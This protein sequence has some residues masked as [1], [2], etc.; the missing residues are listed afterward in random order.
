MADIQLTTLSTKKLADLYAQ[1]EERVVPVMTSAMS[2]TAIA[3]IADLKT[4]MR[5]GNDTNHVRSGRLRNSMG[6]ETKAEGSLIKTLL[7]SMGVVYARIQEFGGLI[8]PKRGKYLA[9][10]LSA[11]KTKAGVAR[12]ASPRDIPGLVFLKS[13]TGNPI[14]AQRVAKGK[15]SKLVPMFVLVKSVTLKPTLGLRDT[16]KKFFGGAGSQFEG[17]IMKGVE[18]VMRG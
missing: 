11:A 10:P 17:E 3:T 4:R 7:G 14:L 18:K 1:R 12:Y 15:K 2:R 16:I 6:Q 9:I 13:K 5:G 8:K